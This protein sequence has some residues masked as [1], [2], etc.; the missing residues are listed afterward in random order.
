MTQQLRVIA[1]KFKRA[2]QQLGKIHGAGALAALL[3]LGIQPDHLLQCRIVAAVQVLRPAAFVLVLVD[4]VLHFTR[5]PAILI[6]LQRLQ[7]LL[8]DA[9]LIVGIQD[10]EALRQAGLAPVEAQ[11]AVGQAM[12]RAQPQRAARHSQQALDT[13]AHFGSGL[14]GEGDGQDAVR[15]DTLCG[16]Q[17][18]DAMDEYP[19]LAT[20]GT[21]E[22][23]RRQQ[24]GCDRLAL[25]IVQRA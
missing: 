24:R 21:G 11:Q 1:P 9:Q 4:E 5:H 2:Q 18:G 17:P 7:Q 3:I 6:Q 13:G 10:L 16:D 12:K 8:D 15:A 14:V 19:R 23:Q 25:G 20:A 22:H